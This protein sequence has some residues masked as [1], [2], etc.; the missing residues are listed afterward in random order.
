MP[1]VERQPIGPHARRH[2]DLF[3]RRVAGALADAVDRALD[4]PRAGADRRQRVGDREAEV[5]VAVRAED[6]VVRRSARAPMI[7]R[8]N[9]P[10]SSGVE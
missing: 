5:V 4:L 10:I 8:K 9:A 6:R 1:V 3:E 7:V 2:D